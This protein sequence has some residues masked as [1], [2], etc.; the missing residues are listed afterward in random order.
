MDFEPIL[1]KEMQGA[2]AD[3]IEDMVLV[4]FRSDVV[5]RIPFFLANNLFN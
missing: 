1:F 5:R 2:H 4:V 3:K